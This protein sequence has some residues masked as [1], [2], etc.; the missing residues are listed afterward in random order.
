MLTMWVSRFGLERSGR[1]L[2]LLLLVGWLLRVVL[3]VL[4]EHPGLFDP[5]H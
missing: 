1:Q 3:A 5:N 2:A 4:A